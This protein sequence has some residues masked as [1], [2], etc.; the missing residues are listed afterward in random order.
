MPLKAKCPICRKPSQQGDDYF[1][2][3]SE[4][5]QAQDLGHWASE[6][7]RIPGPTLERLPHS[8]EEDIED[9]TSNR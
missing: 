4:R 6:D 8:T 2:F 5:C 3:C 7:Y 1:P 9:E